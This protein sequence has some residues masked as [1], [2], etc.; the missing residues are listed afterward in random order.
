MS[1]TTASSSSSTP[2]GSGPSRTHDMLTCQICCQYYEDPRRLPCGHTF[3]FRCLER[4]ASRST[5]HHDPSSSSSTGRSSS[6][7]RGP[8]DLMPCPNAP[9]C[10]HVARIPPEGVAG[11]PVDDRVSK[12]KDRVVSEMAERILRGSRRRQQQD[13]S[14]DAA[15][16]ASFGTTY[17]APADGRLNVDSDDD[18]QDTWRTRPGGKQYS[19]GN[20]NLN[21]YSRFYP[22]ENGDKDQDDE[23][24]GREEGSPGPLPRFDIP[25]STG[26]GSST[27]GGGAGGQR[28]G[29]RVGY[30][31]SFQHRRRRVHVGSPTAFDDASPVA[32]ILR[33]RR[34]ARQQGPSRSGSAPHL[35]EDPTAGLH[36]RRGRISSNYGY[37]MVI[38]C[39]CYCCHSLNV[40]FML[41]GRLISPQI[42]VSQLNWK[43]CCVALAA[44]K[45]NSSD[46]H[47]YI[48]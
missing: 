32:E 1:A 45:S 31:S 29:R 9:S 6:V 24:D 33:Q 42:K 38:L 17:S 5:R 39:Y 21:K 30:S 28:P 41:F 35:E 3:C 16:E 23:N 19:P 48:L 34:A 40:G 8:V 26:T 14:M 44:P 18:D 15:S 20:P 47:F 25:G 46:R 12:I 7:T 10:L 37:L 22:T 13:E 36:S 27:L 4:Y 43:N 2:L 11:F